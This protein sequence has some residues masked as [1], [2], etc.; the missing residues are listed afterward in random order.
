MANPNKKSLDI[1]KWKEEKVLKELIK[2]WYEKEKIKK[3]LEEIKI[4]EEKE[5]KESFVKK[6][7]SIDEWG[8]TE[9]IEYLVSLLEEKKS[10]IENTQAKI[11]KTRNDVN[12]SV[13]KKVKEVWEKVKDWIMDKLWITWIVSKLKLM[14]KEITALFAWFSIAS[15]FWETKKDKEVKNEE[16]MTTEKIQEQLVK[17]WKVE[18]EPKTEEEENTNWESIEKKKKQK[19][20]WYTLLWRKFIEKLSPSK[21]LFNKENNNFNLFANWVQ[22]S[23]YNTYSDIKELRNEVIKNMWDKLLKNKILKRLNIS[24]NI[25]KDNKELLWMLDVL[26]WNNTD[27]IIKNKLEDIDWIISSKK[28]QKTF[29]DKY[30]NLKWKDYKELKLNEI[31][32]L[33]WYTLPIAAMSWFKSILPN[34][35]EIGETKDVIEEEIENRKDWFF[36]KEFIQT[37]WSWFNQP[38]L[39]ETKELRKKFNKSKNINETTTNDLEKFIAFKNSVISQLDNKKWS[40]EQGNFKENFQEK[41]TPLDIYNLYLLLDWNTNLNWLNWTNKILMYLWIS[42]IPNNTTY[43]DNYLKLL[44][45]NNSKE[46]DKY[47]TK[48]E[49][50]FLYPLLTQWAHKL[51]LEKAIEIASTQKTIIDTWVN[52]QIKDSELSDLMKEY[53][54]E[55]NLSKYKIEEYIILASILWITYFSTKLP[56]PLHFK[57]LLS[58]L[59]STTWITYLVW[60][61]KERWVLDKMIEDQTLPEEIR[62]ALRNNQ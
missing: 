43:R 39:L 30:D 37:I 42:K 23:Q 22:D 18:V 35:E 12:N 21:I 8:S 32:L 57:I 53:W 49:E 15:I 33:I 55:I 34:I 24:P 62:N 47:L 58:G 44:Y 9:H 16:D 14:W 36:S 31:E 59:V 19:I 46:N 38:W 2:K 27:F 61:L 25:V 26:A 60:A 51:L 28:F 56:L 48:E 6:L 5:N 13:E 11:E 17:E 41:I 10:V 45:E 4:L 52:K 20:T 1:Y 7:D 40:L 54:I 50:Y 29:W 3:R